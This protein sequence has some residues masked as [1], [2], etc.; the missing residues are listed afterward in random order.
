[1]L[2][3]VEGAPGLLLG[4]VDRAVGRIAESPRLRVKVGA[5]DGPGRRQR[6]LQLNGIAHGSTSV[7]LSILS[8]LALRTPSLP[9]A[10]PVGIQGRC[11]P[12]G[13]PSA[14]P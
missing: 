3:E 7:T 14:D 6:Q 9:R 1:V 10:K 13:G 2:E 5:A 8:S 12:S 11:A 4:V